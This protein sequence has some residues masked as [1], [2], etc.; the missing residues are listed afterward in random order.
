M[1][2]HLFPLVCRNSNSF[3]F[4][5]RIRART[6]TLRRSELVVLIVRAVLAVALSVVSIGAFPQQLSPSASEPSQTKQSPAPK[7]QKGTNQTPSSTNAVAAASAAM[8]GRTR[9]AEAAPADA[10]TQQQKSTHDWWTE[11]DWWVAIGT[12]ILAAITGGLAYFTFQLWSDTGKTI[13]IAQQSADAAVSNAQMTKEVVRGRM[14]LNASAGWYGTD[15]SRSIQGSIVF[16]NAGQT[17]VYEIINVMVFG[18]FDSPKV[19]FPLDQSATYRRTMVGAGVRDH[20]G[21]SWKLLD[22]HE[23]ARI[24]RGEQSF[25]IYGRMDYRDIFGDPQFIEYRYV[26]CGEID[27]W[28]FRMCSEGN[29]TSES[30]RRI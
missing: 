20:D 15:T 6:P 12:G 25:Y 18:L 3:Q 2:R 9:D 11:A 26:S 21:L 30:E 5:I 14:V 22:S 27:M 17:P 8:A 29:R 16:H 10:G 28:K 7:Y 24:E 19:G 23:R 4:A 1:P 13:A